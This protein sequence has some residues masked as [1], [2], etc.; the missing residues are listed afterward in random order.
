[1]RSARRVVRESPLSH[2]TR[3]PPWR[4]Y[5][6]VFADILNECARFGSIVAFEIPR[7]MK[8]P[9]SKVQVQGIGKVFV[10][11]KVV[12]EAALAQASLA[13]RQF[14]RRTIITTFFPDSNF[15]AGKFG[16][17]VLAR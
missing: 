10:R 13:C 15:D 11:Y 4:S 5:E 1:M 17:A 7:P 14:R 2:P 16:P 6:V 8:P 3:S 12:E 9:F